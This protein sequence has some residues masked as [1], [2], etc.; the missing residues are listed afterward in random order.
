MLRRTMRDDLP[1]ECR[2]AQARLS[3]VARD[4]DEALT[5]LH[6]TVRGIHPPIL[7]HGGLAP[8]IRALAR[9]SPVPVEL[10]IRVP[11]RLPELTEA[12]AYYVAAEALANAAKH[13]NATAVWIRAETRAGH[14][15]LSVRDDG[16]GGVDPQA[17]SGITGLMDRVEGIGGTITI[18]GPAGGGAS[19]RVDLPFAPKP[20]SMTPSIDRPAPGGGH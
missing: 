11:E 10:D 1:A 5:D 16:V 14:L 19:L 13:A 8:A 18:S 7:T 17:G 6:E 20:G 9:R 3:E 2:Q 12:T 15:Q 4:L